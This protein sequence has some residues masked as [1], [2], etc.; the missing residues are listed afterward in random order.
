MF[1]T[2]YEFSSRFCGVSCCLDPNGDA[3][4]AVMLP[5]ACWLD[6]TGTP[7][8]FLFGRNGDPRPA[9]ILLPD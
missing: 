1:L 8:V 4:P 3:R 5:P 9:V 2:L 7:C 6:L